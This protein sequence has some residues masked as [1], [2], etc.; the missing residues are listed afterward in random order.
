M[1]QITVGSAHPYMGHSERLRL[2]GAVASYRWDDFTDEPSEPR[3]DINGCAMMW[4]VFEGRTAYEEYSESAL[5]HG[6]KPPDRTPNLIARWTNA[7]G[8]M[9]VN[10]RKHLIIGLRRPPSSAFDAYMIGNILVGNRLFFTIRGL[11]FVE[12]EDLHAAPVKGFLERC[13]PA[14]FDD[15]ADLT[16]DPPDQGDEH[17]RGDMLIRNGRPWQIPRPES[18]L[19]D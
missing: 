16:F 19:R 7:A 6:A 8:F 14:F 11:R 5:N 3:P 1:W 12:R 15:W 2:S 18:E 17:R 9:W 4:Y 10:T 13:E